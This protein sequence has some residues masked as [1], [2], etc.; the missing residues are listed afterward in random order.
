MMELLPPKYDFVFH[1]LFGEAQKGSL[2]KM[3]SAIVGREVKVLS[4]DRDRYVE[5]ESPDDKFG[6]M[7]LRAEL[8]N[9]EECNI[10]IQLASYPGMMDRLMFYWADNFKRQLKAGMQYSE[11]KKTI[12]ILIMGENIKEFEALKGDEIEWKI[13]NK[14]KS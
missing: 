4:I 7:D 3:I 6:I 11:L 14:K 2:A 1:A 10:E 12:S 5:L 8:D 13:L 9:N